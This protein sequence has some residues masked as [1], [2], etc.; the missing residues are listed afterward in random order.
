MNARMLVKLSSWPQSPLVHPLIAIAS[1][2]LDLPSK[3]GQRV[4]VELGC[5]QQNTIAGSN[6]AIQ[7]RY[8]QVPGILS[9]RQQSVPFITDVEVAC[10]R[11]VCLIDITR[12]ST[13]HRVAAV[14]DVLI[15]QVTS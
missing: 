8:V 12:I 6:S 13:E 2:M 14:R 3:I 11:P 7:E 4:N 15:R 1:Q 10:V 9:L 5:R